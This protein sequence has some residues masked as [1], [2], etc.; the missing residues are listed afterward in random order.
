[1]RNQSALTVLAY[2]AMCLI[3]GTTWLAIKIGLHDLAPLTG[4]G[5]R[6]LTAGVALYVV[7]AARNELRPLRALP[8][9]VIAVFAV[10]LFGVN[11]VLLYAAETR[12]ESGLVS[13]LFGTLPF[14][15]LG[16]GRL[17]LGERI[18]SR[19]WIGAAC[20]FAG[21]VAIL[22][23]G[24]SA[25]SPMFALA[26]IGAAAASAYANVYAKRF[27]QHS[28]LVTLPPAMLLAGTA[29]FS[30]GTATEHTV[31]SRALTGS[32]LG[33]LLYLA[34]LGSGVAFFILLWLLRR[35]P[36]WKVGLGSLLYPVIAIIAGVLFGGEHVTVRELA[37]S[38]LVLG[39]M[40]IALT[41]APIRE[42]ISRAVLTL[43][44]PPYYR[45]DT[46]DIGK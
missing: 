32:S 27:T 42:L 30:L 17:M 16:F 13:I 15:A 6:F 44:D 39:G 14:F 43:L 1:M 5:L 19:V 21:V 20:A 8:W 7:A 31:W 4:V 23:A 2:A 35:L 10:F 18:A 41:E 40:S 22:I 46:T 11:Y 33:A 29:V 38:L 26:A 12:L 37:G 28:P 9:N 45:A 36:A 3:W 24:A 25:A 34:I